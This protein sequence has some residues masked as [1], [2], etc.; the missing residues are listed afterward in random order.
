MQ[1]QLQRE[2]MLLIHFCGAMETPLPP[3]QMFQETLRLL[4]PTPAGVLPQRWCT[5]HKPPGWQQVFP[6][7][8]FASGSKLFL[9]IIPRSAAETSRHGV[10]ISEM[11]IF[12]RSKIPFTLIPHPELI[13]LR[14]RLLPIMAA[15][16]P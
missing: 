8:A 4:Y 2:E 12:P 9:P 10:G 7:T 3:F 13:Q 14:L 15:R 1:Q 11:E 5:Y 16:I 6:T